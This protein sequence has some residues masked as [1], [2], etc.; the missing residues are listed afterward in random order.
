MVQEADRPI[1]FSDASIPLQFDYRALWSLWR[2]MAQEADLPDPFPRLQI[3]YKPFTKRSTLEPRIHRGS[4]G[5]S[6]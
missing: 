1:G 2:L 3:L 4:V 6:A 5:R